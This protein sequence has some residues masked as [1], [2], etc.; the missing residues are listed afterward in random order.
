MR[1]KC[2]RLG[3]FVPLGIH[4][5]SAPKNGEKA[6]YKNRVDV[7]GKRCLDCGDS[8]FHR[9]NRNHICPSHFSRQAGRCP[10]TGKM[11][12]SSKTPQQNLVNRILFDSF[13]M[14][15]ILCSSGFGAIGGNLDP[16]WGPR[17]RAF[18]A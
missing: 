3:R 11:K 14:G 9:G 8:V 2:L 17:N 4:I 13:Q 15:K 1:Y 12:D 7:T 18:G 5:L 6:A 10:I 16:F